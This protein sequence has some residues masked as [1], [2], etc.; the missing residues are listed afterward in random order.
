L[1]NLLA[2]SE[3]ARSIREYAE[4]EG[5]DLGQCCA[6]SDS[7][8]DVPMLSSVGNPVAT[9]PTPR[10]RRIASQNN[11]PVL[12]LGDQTP[13]YPPFLQPAKSLQ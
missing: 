1:G 8:A 11:W 13:R 10:L 5:I 2:E 7:A 12:D 4:R 6:F 3:K 9:N